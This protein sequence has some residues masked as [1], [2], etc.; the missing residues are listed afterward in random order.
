MLTTSPLHSDITFKVGDALASVGVRAARH[1]EHSDKFVSIS[2]NCICRLNTLLWWMIH[3]TKRYLIFKYLASLLISYQHTSGEIYHF[4]CES[5]FSLLKFLIA[6]CLS[7]GSV[8]MKQFSYAVDERK[9][10]KELITSTL[11]YSSPPCRRTTT[12]LLY[13]RT[14]SLARIYHRQTSPRPHN[15][16]MLIHPSRSMRRMRV[17]GPCPQHH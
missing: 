7:Q 14:T 16:H 11:D 10:R 6:A 9:Q 4:N 13:R 5:S 12:F 2:I 3:I 17:G 1:W 8:R 15:H